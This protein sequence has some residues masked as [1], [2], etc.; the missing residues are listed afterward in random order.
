MKVWVRKGI[1]DILSIGIDGPQS[2]PLL[3]RGRVK[4]GEGGGLESAIGIV[5]VSR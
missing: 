5:G 3:G 4:E 1:L 2:I